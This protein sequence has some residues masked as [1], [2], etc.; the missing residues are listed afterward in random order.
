MQMRSVAAYRLWC[1][2]E[3]ARA[4]YIS[5][6][7][8]TNI[9]ATRYNSISKKANKVG[10]EAIPFSSNSLCG[11]FGHDGELVVV[12]LPYYADKPL[13]DLRYRLFEYQLRKLNPHIV[14]SRLQTFMI[15]LTV[16]TTDYC[17]EA[18]ADIQL[19][20]DQVSVFLSTVL[21]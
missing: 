18:E 3:L 14:L 21:K 7:D 17:F 19:A 10:N 8:P 13:E 11:P 20:L 1:D 2:I 4:G 16:I 12:L 9:N 5:R 15:W 6:L